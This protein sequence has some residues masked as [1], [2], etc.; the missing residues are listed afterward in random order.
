VVYSSWYGV[1]APKA[2]PDT[3]AKALNGAI[4]AAIDELAKSGALGKLGVEPVQ[5]TIEQ[6][7]R[8][9]DADVQRSVELLK[10]VGFKPE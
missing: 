7:K 1:W 3:T 10:A 9:V 5:E 8:F 6:F 4:N 2:L